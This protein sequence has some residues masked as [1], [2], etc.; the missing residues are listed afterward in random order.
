MSTA[1][2]K[3]VAR[4]V[5]RRG[6]LKD[7][8][9]GLTAKGRAYF[10]RTQGAHLKAGVKKSQRDMSPQDMRARALDLQH[11]RNAA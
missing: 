3:R 10:Q 6:A 4:P 5:K 1:T 8:K 11:L 7:P 9:G 2:R